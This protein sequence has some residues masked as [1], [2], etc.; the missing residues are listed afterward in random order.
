MTAF[1]FY[2][3]ASSLIAGLVC[4][5]I[6]LYVIARSQTLLTR[7]Y[8]LMCLVFFGIGFSDMLTRSAAGPEEAM[9][10]QLMVISGYTIIYPLLLHFAYALLGP[11]KKAIYMAYFPMLILL[12]L[13]FIFSDLF[14]ASMEKR[15]YGFYYDPGPMN[16]IYLAFLAGCTITGLVLGAISFRRAK[17]YYRR[18]Q[19]KLFLFTIPVPLIV[20]VLTNQILIIMDIPSLPLAIQAV[21]LFI[22]LI[23]YGLIRYEPV[24][25]I[26]RKKIASEAA[27]AYPAPL[28]LTDE[29]N[30]ITFANKSALEL[31]GYDQDKLV[32]MKIKQLLSK[33]GEKDYFLNKKGNKMEIDLRIYP[34]KKAGSIY[35]VRDLSQIAEITEAV[36]KDNKELQALVDREKQEIDF[37]FEL[38]ECEDP[39]EADR[40]WRRIEKAG[41][42]TREV[43]RPVYNLVLPYTR[44]LEEEKQARDKLKARKEQLEVLREA[45]AGR[46]KKARELKR[47]LKKQ[48]SQANGS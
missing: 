23:G 13:Y 9:F 40:I 18:Q 48:I 10:W 1:I 44:A 39:Q 21:A 17:Q 4:L 12:P 7:L 31:S 41:A 42:E 11:G 28:F 8:F 3:S 14:I 34:V 2:Y 5:G 20:G 30:T 37:L 35:Q 33:S 46:E 22:G 38:A 36:K 6:G 24:R 47:E 25:K 19:A 43:L 16:W 45:M 27:L 32:T 26:S 29:K 15:I